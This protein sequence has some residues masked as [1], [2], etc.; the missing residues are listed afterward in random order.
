MLYAFLAIVSGAM[1]S[2][3]SSY[4]GMLY[5]FIGVLG[6][7]FISQ[8][9]N[10]ATSLV[11]EVAS[12]KKFPRTNGMPF[13]VCLGGVCAIFVLGF[14]GYLVA[15]LG[16]AV[17]VCLSVSGQ[18]IMSAI[19]DHFGLFGSDKVSFRPS[20]IPGFLCILAGIFVINFV[21]ADSFTSVPNKA[22]LFLLL[23]F[24]IFIGC[25]TVFARMFNYEAS[26]YVGKVAGSFYNAGFGAIIALILFIV[27]AGFKPPFS[28][29]LEAP[30]I[31]YLTGPLGA[32]ACVLNNI[33]Y[34]KM[35][36]FH[37]TIF[38]LIGQISA[39]IIA[40]LILL[41]NFPLGK[42]L[43][44]LIICIGIFL[45]KRASREKS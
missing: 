4:N 29:F 5:A 45:D 27:C 16:S 25:L 15:H 24:A 34:D 21:G 43:G 23:I 39:S 19:V 37:A 44:I 13:H 14:S 18:L 22:F 28:G 20:R 40:D 11:L 30:K 6:V 8:F 35:K 2:A 36:V 10:A 12:T 9:L 7:G 32:F 33:A 41:G 1:I 42:L 31:A 26:Q 38:L 3:Q 17:T